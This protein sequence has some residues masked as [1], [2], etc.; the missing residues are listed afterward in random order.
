[1]DEQFRE[2]TIRRGDFDK[3]RR[4]EDKHRATWRDLRKHSRRPH[5][6][7]PAKGMKYYVITPKTGKV[8]LARMVKRLN[9]C[10]S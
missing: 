7:G 2:R 4:L 1:M 5:K 6:V 8:L 3:L 10:Q 9:L